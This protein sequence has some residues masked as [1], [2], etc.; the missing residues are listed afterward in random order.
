MTTPSCANT[1]A[2]TD[3]TRS[4]W[5]K[6]CTWSPRAAPSGKTQGDSPSSMSS[7]QVLPV[8]HRPFSPS[9]SS[10]L[11]SS[12][13]VGSGPRGCAEAS[14]VIG[15]SCRQSPRPSFQGLL[16]ERGPAL[17]SPEAP[18]FI[19][20]KQLNG[21]GPLQVGQ[22]CRAPISQPKDPLYSCRSPSSLQSPTTGRHW[23]GEGTPSITSPDQILGKRSP[24]TTVLPLLSPPN[25]LRSTTKSRLL[26]G[27]VPG[28]QPLSQWP[29]CPSPRPGQVF[30]TS[31]LTRS[32]RKNSSLSPPGGHLSMPL[33]RL[34][35]HPIRKT[36]GKKKSTRVFSGEN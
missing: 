27:C 17:L 18:A 33:S 31:P 6:R 16:P 32:Q 36:V 4:S 24:T 7:G 2:S 10:P 13:A 22:V 28:G 14:N 35:L 26:G 23:N 5:Q 1:G 29:P 21:S 20:R 34:V 15:S 9:L 3:F 19:P 30:P 12:S 8:G 25:L 11:P